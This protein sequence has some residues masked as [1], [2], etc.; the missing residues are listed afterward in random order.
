MSSAGYTFDNSCHMVKLLCA[1]S[2]RVAGVHCCMAM[3]GGCID[4]QDA[5]TSH[6]LSSLSKL[7]STRAQQRHARALVKKQTSRLP[8]VLNNPHV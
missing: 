8:F 5:V 4:T 2:F 3:Q 1:R 7:K 6:P